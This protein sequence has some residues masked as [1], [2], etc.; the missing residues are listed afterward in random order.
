M[1]MLNEEKT[2]NIHYLTLL[3]DFFHFENKDINYIKIYKII[4]NMG[5][6]H[7]QSRTTFRKF[8]YA[9]YTYKKKIFMT[10]HFFF[11]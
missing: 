1:P 2:K 5:I 7:N 9:N 4:Q 11:S 8:L 3:T 6:P 10:K